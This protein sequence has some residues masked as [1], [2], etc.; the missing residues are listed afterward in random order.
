MV[1]RE[2]SRPVSAENRLDELG[3]KLPAPRETLTT[4]G[5]YGNLK[6]CKRADEVGANF[7][8]GGR[9]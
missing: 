1:A 4:G 5:S 9:F 8:T 2:P 6:G 3:I 7:Q